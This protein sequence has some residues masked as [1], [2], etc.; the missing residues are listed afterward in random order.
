MMLI[1]AHSSVNV[2]QEDTEKKKNRWKHYFLRSIHM[3]NRAPC[4]QGHMFRFDGL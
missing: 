4:I 3:S 1:H 2:L